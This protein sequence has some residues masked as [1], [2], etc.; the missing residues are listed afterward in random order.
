MRAPVQPLV[1]TV[2]NLEVLTFFGLFTCKCILFYIC[3][4][5]CS[6]MCVLYCVVPVKFV[7]VDGVLVYVR[8]VR[9][10]CVLSVSA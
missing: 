1:K 9:V 4:L 7:H 3:L 2:L 8:V 5:C 10:W 6:V